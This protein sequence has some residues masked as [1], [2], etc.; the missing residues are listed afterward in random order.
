MS[1]SQFGDWF[2]FT[3]NDAGTYKF[4][5]SPENAT[6]HGFVYYY[7]WYNGSDYPVLLYDNEG[8]LLSNSLY[9]IDNANA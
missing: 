8:T 7:D 6:S 3:V 5:I 4:E 1:V 9:P 2:S